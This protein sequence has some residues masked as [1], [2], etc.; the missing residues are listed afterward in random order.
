MGDG[1]LRADAVFLRARGPGNRIRIPL[2][3][4][5]RGPS[6][7]RSGG[8]TTHRVRHCES[9]NHRPGEPVAHHHEL[10][11]WDVNVAD[12]HPAPVRG[13]VRS[14]QRDDQLLR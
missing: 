13:A 5:L 4:T 12:G 7:P 1:R 14:P 6:L 8:H 10:A 3:A 2:R 9:G 11:A